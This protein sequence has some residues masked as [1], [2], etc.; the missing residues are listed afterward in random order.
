MSR[1]NPLVV[2][3]D[4]A[5]ILREQGYQAHHIIP[6][7]IMNKNNTIYKKARDVILAAGFDNGSFSRNGIFLPNGKADQATHNKRSVHRGPHPAY[8][9]YVDKQLSE[10]H[11]KSIEEQKVGVKK[12]LAELRADLKEGNWTLNKAVDH[13]NQLELSEFCANLESTGLAD[14]YAASNSNASV[15]S[16]AVDSLDGPGGV[17]VDSGVLKGLAE[18]PDCLWAEKIVVALPVG[19]NDK[20]W[21]IEASRHDVL[22]QI[23]ESLKIGRAVGASPYYS[24]HFPMDGKKSD[25]FSLPLMF[26]L[27]HPVFKDNIVGQI[28]AHLDYAM[29]AFMN[30]VYYSDRL[31]SDFPTLFNKSP[32]KAVEQEFLK[33]YII[34]L[35]KYCSERKIPY[36]TNEEIYLEHGLELN[37]SHH[38]DQA[39]RD[40]AARAAV[41]PTVS[42]LK[43]HNSARIYAKQK[44]IRRRGSLFVLDPDFEIGYTIE[45]TEAQQRKLDEYEQEHGSYP[46]DFLKFERAYA[47][48]AQMIRNVMP[49]LPIFRPLFE[50]ASLL[51][52][53]CYLTET[54]ET[55]G[56]VPCSIGAPERNTD[57]I[58]H[59]D[60]EEGTVKGFYYDKEESTGMRI[61]KTPRGTHLP[62]INILPS[63]PLKRIKGYPVTIN[64][65]NIFENLGSSL[66]NELNDITVQE[67][68]GCSPGMSD[69]LTEELENSLRGHIRPQISPEEVSEN[70]FA[71]K[72]IGSEIIMPAR[73]AAVA[74]TTLP[75]LT[76]F[77]AR[78]A[79]EN[80]KSAI[81]GPLHF[82]KT[83]TALMKRAKESFVI[84]LLKGVYKTPYVA[85][86]YGYEQHFLLLP[87]AKEFLEHCGITLCLN[88]EEESFNICVKKWESAVELCIENNNKIENKKGLLKG[89]SELK[90]IFIGKKSNWRQHLCDVDLDPVQDNTFVTAFPSLYRGRSILL[91]SQTRV[92]L[93]Q[94]L[95]T[96][97]KHAWEIDP[98]ILVNCHI[99]INS[100]EAWRTG[101]PIP[102]PEAK[103]ENRQ[104]LQDLVREGIVISYR[105]VTREHSIQFNDNTVEWLTLRNTSF[106]FKKQNP[107]A[108]WLSYTPSSEQ[109][110]DIGAGIVPIASESHNRDKDNAIYLDNTLKQP[111]GKEKWISFYHPRQKI[112]EKIEEY[113]HAQ[114]SN[115]NSKGAATKQPNLQVAKDA[116][117]EPAHSDNMVSWVSAHFKAIMKES[118]VPRS[119][120]FEAYLEYCVRVESERNALDEEVKKTTE[121]FD[122]GN[123]IQDL[124][125]FAKGKDKTDES[126]YYKDAQRMGKWIN[127]YTT[128][129]AYRNVE[130]VRNIFETAFKCDC[131]KDELYCLIMMQLTGNSPRSAYSKSRAWELLWLACG[132][133]PCSFTIKKDSHGVYS[134]PLRVVHEFLK[135]QKNSF[136][137]ECIKR[138]SK[139]ALN[140]P[141]KH[142]PTSEEVRAIQNI[143]NQD[144]AVTDEK[145]LPR[146]KVSPLECEIHIP[147][148]SEPYKIKIESFSR[149][150]DICA[151]MG[152]KLGLNLPKN[153]NLFFEHVGD[154]YNK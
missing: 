37:E 61:T 40:E 114:D 1:P 115:I 18:A 152:D 10:L 25:P 124:L 110:D 38:I 20:A 131:L 93:P 129:N 77:A 64:W 101:K 154:R 15:T 32:E 98:L 145:Y 86:Y 120:L 144:S 41:V 102:A 66:N 116:S 5:K 106:F 82:Q 148:K 63:L 75:N 134:D 107:Q 13:R 80:Y 128:E 57:K 94:H 34:D 58:F 59:N 7:E 2:S 55:I 54:M 133:F 79:V 146:R 123:G 141:R 33:G 103:G 117:L 17:V 99:K 95:K 27:I 73:D 127:K 96:A 16:G 135:S 6:E 65:K 44:R 14:S 3:Q 136:A 49:T 31:L 46:D 111:N 42:N 105:K 130:L 48:A 121:A 8:T 140:G 52:F 90:E 19:P 36:K 22:G 12:L 74:P 50:L 132:T 138:I 92:R 150:R 112:S 142:A 83:A 68:Q 76:H 56:R 4:R 125:K 51:S 84:P 85:P 87:R 151:S 67:L 143:Q 109:Y 91:D 118:V 47:S 35:T 147:G 119:L 39:G 62:R 28:I 21:A 43:F 104:T 30:G 60:N 139:T 137:N 72:V 88:V 24:L 153:F 89:F 149:A 45:V 97:P 53:A 69:R 108:R 29:K 71:S 11:D 81:T 23:V 70:L 126:E 9:E 100:R 26:G 78:K 122:L 113:A